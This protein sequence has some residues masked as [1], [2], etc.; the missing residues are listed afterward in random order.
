MSGHVVGGGFIVARKMFQ[1]NIWLKHPLYLKVWVWII[2]RANHSDRK[3]N[4]HTYKRGEFVTT[5]DELI[6]AASYY[7]NRSLIFPTLK[8]IRNILS[9]LESEGMIIVEPIRDSELPT[10][11]DTRVRTRAYVGVKIIVIKYD[12]YQDLESYKGRHKGRPSS[13]LGHNNKNGYNNG[14]NI[15]DFFSLRERYDQALIDKIFQAIASTRKSGKVSDS[16]LVAQLKKWERYPI[17]QVEAGIRI[18][19]DRDCAGQGKR[20]N[21]LSAIIGNHQN[22]A[23]AKPESAGSVLLDAHYAN[24]S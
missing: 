19:L 15:S 3:K 23:E 4:N 20:E 6:K 11:A 1:S 22:Q 18:Y 7:F 8:Q 24:A 21:Y 14:K 17:Q 16:I 9:W 2:G 13:Q 5:Y 10:G 12:T